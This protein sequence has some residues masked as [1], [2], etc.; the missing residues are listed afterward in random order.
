[1][2]TEPHRVGSSRASSKAGR[3]DDHERDQIADER[4]EV[5]VVMPVAQP[6]D[7]RGGERECEQ[8]QHNRAD[9]LAASR[10][11]VAPCGVP[12]PRGQRESDDR[13]RDA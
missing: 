12:G 8:F 6:Y 7:G 10:R 2:I 13:G 1:M 11:L 4:G 3:R 5:V 9:Q